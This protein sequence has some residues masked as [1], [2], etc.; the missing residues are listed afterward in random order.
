MNSL[1]RGLSALIPDIRKTQSTALKA[2]KNR[3]EIAIEK[4]KPNPH[5]PRKHFDEISLNE[6][7]ASIKEHGILPVSYTHLTL[8]TIYSV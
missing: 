7:A 4:I 2:T 6:L 5:Q 1:G 3:E 8:P